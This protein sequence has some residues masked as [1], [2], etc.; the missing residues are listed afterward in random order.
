MA[1]KFYNEVVPIV[2]RRQQ[3]H[4]KTG[5]AHFIKNF[6]NQYWFLITNTLFAKSLGP[7]AAPHR[8]RRGSPRSAGDPGPCG[9]GA[10]GAG[11]AGAEGGEG[12]QD[13]QE[14]DQGQ[15]PVSV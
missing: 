6:S 10:C 5:A 15:L 12:R 3:I 4:L 1:R 8:I 7:C 14:S 11:E 9:G 13:R 2:M